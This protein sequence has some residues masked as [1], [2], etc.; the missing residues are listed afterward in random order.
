MKK[1]QLAEKPVAIIYNPISGKSRDIRALVVS[2]LREYGIESILYE[3]EREKHAWEMVQSEID[4][5]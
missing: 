2:K 1:A 3:T 5:S 4:V